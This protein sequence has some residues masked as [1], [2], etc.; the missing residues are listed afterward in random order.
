[1]A[2]C[3]VHRDGAAP[4]EASGSFSR[5]KRVFPTEPGRIAPRGD[6]SRQVSAAGEKSFVWPCLFRVF[7]RQSSIS[8]LA[9]H[10][11]VTHQGKNDP[12]NMPR[13]RRPTGPR[14][15]A[16]CAVLDKILWCHHGDAEGNI[17]VVQ[18]NL[19]NSYEEFG[20]LEQ[21][22][23]MR[24]E[25]YS[26]RMKLDGEEHGDS[27]VAATC[28]ASTLISLNRFEEAKALFRRSIPVALRTLGDSNHLTLQMKLNFAIG[29]YDDDDATLDDLREAVMRIEETERVTRR[30]LGGAHPLTV[31]MEESLRRS[32]AALA[33]REKSR[34]TPSAGA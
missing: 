27:L 12:H 13:L 17:L 28:Y 6:A 9:R 23:S 3:S 25:V 2:A 31:A 29:L 7:D 34:E 11:Q 19:A 32:R 1:M 33:A 22:L 8:Q 26:G 30:V 20:R 16:M 4:G 21:A 14:R 24:Q 5:F 10:S 18:S 15:A